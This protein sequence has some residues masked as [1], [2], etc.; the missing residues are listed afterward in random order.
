M[1]P[2]EKPY[3]EDKRK[4]TAMTK[5]WEFAEDYNKN[6]KDDEMRPLGRFL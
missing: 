5:L 2:L 6:M 3:K 1:R 4:D